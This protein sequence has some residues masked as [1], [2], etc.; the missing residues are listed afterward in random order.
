MDTLSVRVNMQERRTL[1][2]L[3]ER[4]QRTQSDTVRLLIRQAA[5]RLEQSIQK[6][7]ADRRRFSRGARA[8]EQSEQEIDWMKV[9]PNTGAK[10]AS[11]N[12]KEKQ[13]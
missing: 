5:Q 11:E 6:T 13:V 4:L 2:A 7:A 10:L 9:V 12:D 8:R 1:E 3:A